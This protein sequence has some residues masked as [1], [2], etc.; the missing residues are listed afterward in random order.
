MPESFPMNGSN[1]VYSYNKNSSL[2]RSV[3]NSVKVML[4]E[5]I[6]E[7]LDVQTKTFVI[8]DMGCSVGPNT[9]FAMQNVVQAIKH[10]YH[11]TS[12]EFEFLVFFN[13]H[14]K[15]NFNI[16]FDSLFSDHQK[17]Y[18]RSCNSRFFLWPIV[19]LALYS[20]RVFLLRVTL[21]VCGTKGVDRY[22]E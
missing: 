9:F 18:F 15:N 2:Q 13:D 10:K 5:A 1:G 20:C 4:R 6:I 16:L 17:T 22:E 11:S 14:V 12:P 7:N 19:P 21:V 3:A 8:V